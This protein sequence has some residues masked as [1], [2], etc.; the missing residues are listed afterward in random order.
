[1]S[2]GTL[3][4]AMWDD[5]DFWSL[6]DAN[7]K[8]VWIY[9][10]AGPESQNSVP[11]LIH[12]SVSG[13]A[14]GLRMSSV[15]CDSAFRTLTDRSLVEMSRPHRLIRIPRA[16]MHRRPHNPNVLKGYFRKWLDLPKCELKYNHIVSL[17]EATSEAAKSPRGENML[18]TWD[19][20]FGSE[21][22]PSGTLLSTGTVSKRLGERLPKPFRNGSLPLNFNSN[23]DDDLTTFETVTQTVSKPFPNGSNPQSSILDPKS[24]IRKGGSGGISEPP[25]DASE[26]WQLQE[27]LLE[28]LGNARRDPSPADLALVEQALGKFSRTQL[29]HA[30]R[31]DA[32]QAQTDDT[33]RKWFNRSS[34]WKVGHLRYSVDQTMP[35]GSRAS[36]T[37]RKKFAGR[38]V[39]LDP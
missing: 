30:L 10:I 21:K 39:I 34:N 23:D 9:L 32:A 12:A 1:M 16:P 26:L 4:P 27:D 11:G 6:P 2:Y 24:E 13:I 37:G 25:S 18:A 20:T 35:R 38:D 33:A 8:L 29:E 3:D 15:D 14:E 17:F 28:S 31:V 22:D 19:E 5:E 7:S 36:V